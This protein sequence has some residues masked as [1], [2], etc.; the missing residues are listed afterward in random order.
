[1][2]LLRTGNTDR[3]LEILQQIVVNNIEN[4]ALQDARILVL[5]QW[6]RLGRLDDAHDILSQIP[7]LQ[8]TDTDFRYFAA[9]YNRQGRVAEEIEAI[10]FIQN[11][12]IDD[13]QR[14]AYLQSEIGDTMIA[15]ITWNEILRD[16]SASEENVLN[17][18][19]ALG[20]ISFEAGRHAEAIPHYEEFFRLHNPRIADHS[21]IMPPEIVA[22]RLIISCYQTGNRSRAETLTRNL[23]SF[24]RRNEPVLA[25]ISLYEGI[26]FQT[27][28]A[29]RAIRIFS[30]L[31]DG[32]H[33]PEEIRFRAMYQ[34]GVVH[35]RERR[36]EQAESDFINALGAEDLAIRNQARLSLGNL[37]FS[38]QQHESALLQYFEII[39]SD[40]DGNL[41]RD[42]AHNFAIVSRH[43]NDWQ[44][45]ISAY[46][47]IMERWGQAILDPET[48]LTIGFSFFQA[49]EFDQAINILY[50]VLNDLES[51]ELRA[52]AQFWIAE[53]Y[54]GRGSLPE[55]ETAFRNIRA[56]YPRQTRWVALADLKVGQILLEQ[57]QIDR[58]MQ[59]FR[60]V[61]RIHGSG[62]DVGREAARYLN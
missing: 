22:K 38:Q 41:A 48:R 14:L 4:P 32:R 24:I 36:L 18:R 58:A 21:L 53:S 20:N 43:L 46:H 34:R 15:S 27:S 16:A 61:I 60:E 12:S 29:R 44:S 26:F 31:I 54:A 5:N 7:P 11:R 40:I 37:Y 47:I 55:A 8:R 6:L 30:D 42:A 56:N 28:D 59:Q 19:I 52:E 45:V 49:R 39:R 10:G 9:I 25:E 50:H 62:S 57:G 3:A 23:N 17:A 2:S 1:M 33:T 51:D 13:V 35:T